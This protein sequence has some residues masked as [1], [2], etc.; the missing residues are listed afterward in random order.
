M[1]PSAASNSLPVRL[2]HFSDIHL[3]AKPL[4][5][6]LRDLLTKRTTGWMNLRMGRGRH[7]RHADRIVR[8]MMN[9]IRE[10]GGKHIVFSGDATALGFESEFAS[11]ARCLDL[12]LPG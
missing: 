9:D 3:T 5:W 11:A 4:G 6:R 7:F 2:A 10:R 12:N 1:T 8:A